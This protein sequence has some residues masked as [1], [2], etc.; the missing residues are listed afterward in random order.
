MFE[1]RFCPYCGTPLSEGCD[2][3]REIAEYE[4]ELVEELEDRQYRTAGSRI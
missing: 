2:C 1:K 3:A 4:A